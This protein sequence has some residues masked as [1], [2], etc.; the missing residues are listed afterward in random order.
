MAQNALLEQL[1][2]CGLKDI[3]SRGYLPFEL[4]TELGTESGTELGTALGT[5]V[6]TALGT[7]LG[8]EVFEVLPLI[9]IDCHPAVHENRNN[10]IPRAPY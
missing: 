5:K 2:A 9:V 3:A 10:R 4:G 6:G 7:K 1:Q 8:S